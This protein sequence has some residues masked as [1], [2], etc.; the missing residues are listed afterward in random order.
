MFNPVQETK[1]EYKGFPCV[2]L[3]MYMGY[4]CGY[5]GLPKSHKYYGKSYD[6]IPI[7]CHCGLTYSERE[8]H[9]QTDKDVWWIG[10]DCT[11]YCDGY[12]VETAKK[13]YAEDDETM[14]TILTLEK[15]GYFQFGN[16]E[17]TVRTLDFCI[18][19]CKQIV[20]QLLSEVEP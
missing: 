15:T 10:F 18:D 17:N 11:H 7:S 8:L 13:L 12:D 6:K 16:S 3:F 2:V 19:Q 9:C 14:K 4:R 1:F 20:E 5:V